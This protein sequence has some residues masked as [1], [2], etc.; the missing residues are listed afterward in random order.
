MSQFKR[1]L[2]LL[3][4]GLALALA[5]ALLI[6]N[7]LAQEA[8]S[9]DKAESKER[10]DLVLKGDAQCTR[11]HD[12]GDDFPVLA[13]GKTKHGTVADGR[14]PSCT[15]CHGASE[16]HMNKGDDA[17]RAKPERTFT[18]S[19][20]TPVAERNDACMSCHR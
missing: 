16:R 19:S 10:K 9:E 15:S 7:A 5:G 12:A 2:T 18:K 17:E 4:Q 1:W 14:T 3:L 11:C 8:K 13:I 20:T 6:S